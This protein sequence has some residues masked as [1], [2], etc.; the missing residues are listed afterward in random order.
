MRILILGSSDFAKAFKALGHEVLVWAP[1]SGANPS[2][3]VIDPD[4]S[5][6]V[7]E[8]GGKAAGLDV[9]LVC[10]NLGRRTLPTG[11]WGC[12]ALTVLYGIDA[13]LNRFW[14]ESY[15]RLF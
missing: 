10:D 1:D 9:V 3:A 6:L 11:L 14:Q 13:P 15:A 4:W 7:R 8:L 5:E 12:P 2:R